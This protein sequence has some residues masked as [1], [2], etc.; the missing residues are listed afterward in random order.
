MLREKTTSKEIQ[1]TSSGPSVVEVSSLGRLTVLSLGIVTITAVHKDCFDSFELTVESIDPSSIEI[2]SDI[3]E[4]KIADSL[5]LEAL[6]SHANADDKVVMWSVDNKK[7]V[8]MEGSLLTAKKPG[9]VIVTATT[10][11][12]KTDS[13][14][15]NITSRTKDIIGGGAVV[16]G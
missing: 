4:L 14:E 9:T 7:L 2:I 15:I 16:V 1:W 13:V 12:N 3:N 5:S 6:I 11:N 10:V 8:E